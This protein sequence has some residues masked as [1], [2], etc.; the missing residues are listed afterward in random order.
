VPGAPDRS[1]VLQSLTASGT[2]PEL[3]PMPPLGV[4][5]PKACAI[6]LIH[7]WIAGMPHAS[8]Q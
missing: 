7:A 3:K 5:V 6:A 1:V 8:V 4:Q 2:D